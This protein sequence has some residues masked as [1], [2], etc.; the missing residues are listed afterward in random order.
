MK[1][2][3]VVIDPARSVSTLDRRLLGS[4]LEHLGHTIY[5]GIYEPGSP[6]ADSNGFRTDVMEEVRGLGVPI[7]RYPGGNFVSGHHWLEHVF[8]LEERA[9]LDGVFDFEGPSLTILALPRTTLPVPSN[10]SPSCLIWPFFSSVSFQSIHFLMVCCI[11]SG[12]M[13]Q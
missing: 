10:R 3:S 7:V 11:C 5:T 4:F 13:G 2:Y 1:Q 8:G 12:D 9:A 6:R